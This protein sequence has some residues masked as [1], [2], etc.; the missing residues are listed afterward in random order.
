MK[1][2]NVNVQDKYVEFLDKLVDLGMFPSRNEAIRLAIKNFI[3]NE[4]QFL[5]NFNSDIVKLNDLHKKFVD[6]SEDVKR[7]LYPLYQTSISTV[8]NQH[9]K[10]Y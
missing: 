10:P 5:S 2:L 7:Q 6:F 8:K 3:S 9:Q 4:S 1:R